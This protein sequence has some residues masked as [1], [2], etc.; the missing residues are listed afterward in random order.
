MIVSRSIHVA[1]NG[2]IPFFLRLSGFHYICILHLLYPPICWWTF[3]LLPCLGY[4]RNSAAVNTGV[5][6]SFWIRVFSGYVPRSGIT[7]SYGNPISSFWRNL[8]PVFHG[9]CIHSHQ[10]CSRGHFSPHPHQHLLF[11]DFFND[12]YSDLCEMIPHCSFDLHFS[13]N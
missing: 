7:R 13:N 1:A 4:C 2:M 8:H 9:G 6:L 3:R 5:H 11:V 12:G 10:Q